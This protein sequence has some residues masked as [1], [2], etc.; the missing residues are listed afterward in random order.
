MENEYLKLAEKDDFGFTFTDE[1]DIT[2]STK[3]Y[4]SLA[5][6]V[7]DLRNRLIAVQK[8]FLPLLKNLSKEPEKEM[9]KWPNRKEIL[10]K[11]I[12]KLMVLTTLKNQ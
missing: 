4:T 2:T 6:E 3:E 1:W 10:D 5:D 9:I 8:I 11:Q 7:N 12:E